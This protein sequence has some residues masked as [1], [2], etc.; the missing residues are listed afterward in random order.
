MS[1]CVRP[2][3]NQVTK[4]AE[5]PQ[6]LYIDKV[7]VDTHVVMQRKVA[8]IRTVLKTVEI[9]PAKLVGRVV[10]APGPYG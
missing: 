10:E 1:Q 9:P 2:S 7:V 8:Q 4:R 5:F 3:I 6:T